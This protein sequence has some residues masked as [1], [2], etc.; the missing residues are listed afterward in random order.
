MTN[1]KSFAGK[2]FAFVLFFCLIAGKKAQGQTESYIQ[3]LTGV[4][5]PKDVCAS[6][7]EKFADK[8]LWSAIEKNVTVQNLISFEIRYDTTVALPAKSFDCELL[9]DIVYKDSAMREKKISDVKLDL[10]YDTAKGKAYKGIAYFKF[11][12][13]H[14][15]RVTVK[16]ITSK[17]VDMAKATFL[18]VKNQI[19]IDRTY[20]KRAGD[21]SAP[22]TV[23]LGS[24]PNVT[25]AKNPTSP[26]FSG[27][28]DDHQMTISWG[29]EVFEY[30]KYDL[31]YTFYDAQSYLGTNNFFTGNVTEQILADAF[32]NNATRVSVDQPMYTLNLVYPKGYL[33]VRIRA[34]TYREVDGEMDREEFDWHY[35][36]PFGI[37]GFAVY[38]TPEHNEVEAD[39]HYSL[40]WQYSAAFAEDGKKKE[41]VSYFD[42]G[43]KSRQS[44]TLSNSDNVSIVAE[45]I[46]D[47]QNR[48]A[49]A[50]LPVPTDDHTIHF[51]PSFN[52]NQKEI[53]YSYADFNA[54]IS[55]ISNAQP[56]S[57]SYGSSKYYSPRNPFAGNPNYPNVSEIV[58]DIPDAAGFPF[59]V[60]EFTNDQTGRIRR[61][62]G[63]GPQFQLGSGKETSYYYGKPA[64]DELDRLF[65]SEAGAAAHYSKNMVVDANGQVSVSYV[66]IA[67]K[68]VATALA[69]NVPANVKALESSNNPVHLIKDELIRP[70]GLV[71]D[72]A[73]L[74]V[75]FNSTIMV[76]AA[77]SYDFS[78]EFQGRSLELIFGWNPEKKLCAD[79]YYDV[80]FS[81]SD[82]CGNVVPLTY[83]NH[84]Y[85][86]ITVE[87]SFQYGNGSNSTVPKTPNTL[88]GVVPQY[89]GTITAA[90]PKTGEYNVSYQLVMNKRALDYYME[91]LKQAHV[92]KTKDEINWEYL[93]KLDITACFKDCRDCQTKLGSLLVFSARMR[94]ILEDENIPITSDILE[95]ITHSYGVALD[96]CT[97]H[98]NHNCHL[99]DAC[100]DYRKMML[101][102]VTPGGQYMLYDPT[103]YVFKERRINVFVT[104][105]KGNLAVTDFVKIRRGGVDQM[106]PFNSL[107]EVEVITQWDA[108]WAYLMLPY[109]PEYCKLQECQFESDGKNRDKAM[110]QTDDDIVAGT[111]FSWNHNDYSA[112]VN[113][114]VSVNYIKPPF[115]QSAISGYVHNRVDHYMVGVPVKQGGVVTNGDVSLKQFI[116]FMIYCPDAVKPQNPNHLLDY[117]D[118]DCQLDTH[119]DKSLD[120]WRLF[121]NLYMAIKQEAFRKPEF[122]IQGWVCRNCQIGVNAFGTIYNEKANPNY[123]P[124]LNDFII[125]ENSSHNGLVVKY[126]QETAPNNRVDVYVKKVTVTGSAITVDNVDVVPFQEN[127]ANVLPINN[128]NMNFKEL[129]F[130]EHIINNYNHNIDGTTPPSNCPIASDF[131]FNDEPAQHILTIR[132]AGKY[133]LLNNTN[134]YIKAVEYVHNKSDL[135]SGCGGTDPIMY[136]M[137]PLEVGPQILFQSDHCFLKHEWWDPTDFCVETNSS[138]IDDPYW[139]DY[140]QKTRRFYDT[141]GGEDLNAV[142]SDEVNNGSGTNPIGAP[143][144]GQNCSD[145]ADGWLQKLQGCFDNITDPVVR[146]QKRVALKAA[147]IAT[148]TGGADIRHPF[149]SST[150]APGYSGSADHSFKDAIVRILGPE[151]ENCSS[152]LIDY[153]VPYDDNTPLNDSIATKLSECGYK[154][155]TRFKTEWL[156]QG[157]TSSQ[158]KEL[159]SYI[160]AKYDP[161]FYLTDAQITEL[162]AT[163][164]SGCPVKR[165]FR[166]PGI[167]TRCADPKT[168]TCLK[169]SQLY[170]VQLQFHQHY[171]LFDETSPSYYDALAGYINQVYQM[172]V[173]PS[174]VYAAIEKCKAGG[175]F[176]DGCSDRCP[177][178]QASLEK[179][180]QVMPISEY[181]LRAYCTE[182]CEGTVATF[183]EH[184]TTWLNLTLG[185]NHDFAYYSEHYLYNCN[186]GIYTEPYCGPTKNGKIQVPNGADPCSCPSPNILRCC[187]EYAPF[188]VFR[189]LYPNPVDP[190]LLA[191]FFEMR[192]YLLCQP[193]NLPNISHNESYSN[194]VN[195]FNNLIPVVIPSEGCYLSRQVQSNTQTGNAIIKTPKQSAI[196]KELTSR[197]DQTDACARNVSGNVWHDVNG[198]SD[199]YVNNS[200]A[201][202]VP[203]AIPIPNGL[204][205]YFTTWVHAIYDRIDAKTT[206]NPANG[207]FTFGPQ[208][209]GTFNRIFLS[210]AN[211]N[212]GDNFNPPATLPQGWQHTGQHLG[213]G[214]G[215]DGSNDGMLSLPDG[216]VVNADFG[217]VHSNGSSTQCSSLWQF[218]FTTIVDRCGDIYDTAFHAGDFVLCSQPLTPVFQ[219]DPDACT[220]SLLHTALGNAEHAYDEYVKDFMR[221][222][223]EAYFA[224]CLSV[225]PSLKMEGEQKEYHYTLYY[226]DQSGNLVKTIPP[227]GVVYL[228]DEQLERTKRLRN[229]DNDECYEGSAYPTFTGT[230]QALVVPGAYPQQN[231]G[232]LTLEAW[233]KFSDIN[234]KQVILNKFDDQGYSSGGLGKAGY[235]AY[236]QN[237]KLYFNL[238]GRSHEKWVRKDLHWLYYTLLPDIQTHFYTDGPEV[239]RVRRFKAQ[240]HTENLIT[241][242]GP[243]NKFYH[244]VF[245]YSGDPSDPQPIKI[246]VNGNLQTLNWANGYQ[247]DFNNDG[248]N[249]VAST[250]VPS[251]DQTKYEFEY[252][253]NAFTTASSADL[254]AGSLARMVDGSLTNG[255]NG[256]MKQLRIYNSSPDAPDIRR[257]SYD[258]CLMPAT[259]E[260]LVLW[261]PLNKEVAGKTS[262][263]QSGQSYNITANW[264]D[265]AV[266]QYPNH[267]LPTYYA[268]NSLNQVT[269]Q[270]TPDAGQSKFWYDRLGRL[271]VSQNAEQKT[272]SRS[273]VADRYSYTKYDAQGR[274]A[275]VGEKISA[276]DINSYD[277][278]IDGDLENWMATGS[279]RQVTQTIYDE[280]DPHITVD[281]N[282]L[283]DQLHHFNSRKRVVTSVFRETETGDPAEYNYASHY[284]YDISGNVKRLYQENKRLPNGTDVGIT[285]T[286]DYDFDLISGKVNEVWYQKAKQDQ[287]VYQYHYDADNKLTEALSGRDIATLRYDSRYRYHLHGPL[288]RTEL[289]HDI[290]QGV[291][292]AYT[293][294]GWLKG[295]NGLFLNE[296]H[297]DPDNNFD[298]G[299]DGVRGTDREMIPADV[300][301]YTLGYYANDY[302]PI[303]TRGGRHPISL[304]QF[305]FFGQQAATLGETTGFELFNGNIA[306][307]S[308]ANR[309]LGDPRRPQL[310]PNAY[311]YQYD[312]L[313]RLVEMRS[314]TVFGFN[315]PWNSGTFNPNGDYAESVSYD[316][317]G[318]ILHY[319]RNGFGSN[320][321]MDDLEYEYN[322]PNNNNQLNRVIDHETHS[323][324]TEDIK[325][326]QNPN[327]YEYDKT[328]NLIADHTKDHELNE[329]QWTV[330]GKIK[331]IAKADKDHTIIEYGYDPSGNRISKTVTTDKLTTTTYYFRDATG[332]V[333]AVY[334]KTSRDINM[335]WREQDLYGSSRLGMWKPDIEMNGKGGGD[336][337]GCVPCDICIHP[338]DRVVSPMV[339]LGKKGGG[340]GTNGGGIEIDPGPGTGY[341]ETI[342][343]TRHYELT[344]HLGNVMAT[345]TDKRIE[346]TSNGVDID[347]YIAEVITANDYYPFGMMM[348]G[349][350][351]DA[352]G[353][354]RY[355]YQGSELEG[356][357]AEN[358]Y[359]TFYRAIDPRIGRWLSIDPKLQP[360]E[361]PYISMGDN[362]I[363]LNDP[364][365]DDWVGQKNSDGTYTPYWD[366][367]AT[368][369]GLQK[370]GEMYLGK[371]KIITAIDGKTYHLKPN[372]KWEVVTDIPLTKNPDANT[373]A[374]AP[375]QGNNKK[376]P[377]AISEPPTTKKPS[378]DPSK[379]NGDDEYSRKGLIPFPV[380]SQ[381]PDYIQATVSSTTD[382]ITVGG[383]ITLDRNGWVYIGVSVGVAS[384]G[385]GYTCTVNYVDNP[386]GDKN[387][388]HNFLEGGSY[389]WT[390]G[391][392]VGITHCWSATKSNKTTST[393]WGAVYPAQIGTTYNNNPPVTMY[394]TSISW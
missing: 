276:G 210:S 347:Y 200:G 57:T 172:H 1:Y 186:E 386:N 47:K 3:S 352:G 237:G 74:K 197:T 153:P 310:T 338:V 99:T 158:Y 383:S 350:K 375:R 82:E 184:I 121:R 163:Y 134:L 381:R 357:M 24:G 227:K 148:C 94:K 269:N 299:W 355:G 105:V 221:D 40:N 306:Y 277:T 185:W 212:I 337:I 147:L 204:Y 110:L 42:G 84:P 129:Y 305:G 275:E 157:G 80:K 263:I 160:I 249:N 322:D 380:A 341:D 301:G 255:F 32:K 150:V 295:I 11:I 136:H 65:G 137:A 93:Q 332:N 138:C 361:S 162:L 239:D 19:L 182:D 382:N 21:K 164:I 282:I 145:M 345:I 297:T 4:I 388:L 348:P 354:Y 113:N 331:L 279:N 273:D 45:N 339:K 258:E 123:Y 34:Y 179:F 77:A 379:S 272:P 287:Y 37:A 166:I 51:F 56:M 109:H 360:A 50:V 344:N 89:H 9:V 100:A 35:V 132:Y 330:Y 320:I 52:R 116:K 242:N 266:P 248:Y 394:K 69:G 313:N 377:N 111:D 267:L 222:Y 340:S 366:K 207:T 390:A 43:M 81:I 169:C 376:D 241:V 30:D 240:C 318:N 203:P 302:T 31:E 300:Y 370:K 67:G 90:F 15:V 333:M 365:G 78:Y 351:Y 373:S 392:A 115:D 168:P 122:K 141:Q 224:K 199:G 25:N 79:C 176:N 152:L 312:Q 244:I 170:N 62:G 12:G 85:D 363:K 128:V 346:H 66:D 61:Q 316:A 55:C 387:Q 194:L 139:P 102:D 159:R 225:I 315:D 270:E 20:K 238:F 98:V 252:D 86:S 83:E 49:V 71:R 264:P 117:V 309:A 41:V 198:M 188:T 193:T 247:Y 290:V 368:R 334:D 235:Y 389:S 13:G 327:N 140:F 285:K 319:T 209:C 250:D 323:A 173:A 161:N 232:P 26:N 289:G 257:N 135:T 296:N 108:A 223:R 101:K 236:I 216:T 326:G 192:R 64:Q 359:S 131:E 245:Q 206:V 211:L 87:P 358:D 342:I 22:L 391:W 155:L 27:T 343:G 187:D 335:W 154:L 385:T 393:G 201:L 18:R 7:D 311:S 48:P 254:V 271:V 124:K 107:E 317:N 130:V 371:D 293:L 175:I 177:D 92:M 374:D 217:I 286:L 213:T 167:L 73:N 229:Q 259:R 362:P 190:R 294:Q 215:D 191:F 307:T 2:L 353:G 146:E 280:P 46:L 231:G 14:E 97:Y 284:V 281:P 298:L 369:K 262:D 23:K 328:G 283:L 60:T 356:D 142:L 114:D 195:Y 205:V 260:G 253:I 384:K 274:I 324:Y 59:A 91:Y 58:K 278:R 53:F 291:D 44:V 96:S 226:Y 304:Q 112:F 6:V 54:S 103:N 38:P 144:Y 70:Q 288:A 256:D 76:P 125:E 118:L 106:V 151:V 314:H 36:D 39:I 234:N 321:G 230:N 196:E 178:V 336:C 95:W 127:G 183:R 251:V 367:N 233:V 349:R 219:S 17:Q 208:A 165:P 171:P 243:S 8:Q 143:D 364:F 292:Y 10:H 261:L 214:P 202:T 372:Q 33:L 180:Y 68:T 265:P 88:C 174:A 303:D 156:A 378:T 189:S 104:K 119:C 63:V 120:E 246:Y 16:S 133:P 218:T 181:N 220:K 126:N 325:D 28:G 149:G 329:I 5:K 75:T 228:D 308:Y 29:S 268:Y 72:A